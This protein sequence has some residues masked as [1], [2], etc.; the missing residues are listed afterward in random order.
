[1]QAMLYSNIFPFYS[2]TYSFHLSSLHFIC[3][4]LDCFILLSNISSSWGAILP[5]SASWLSLTVDHFLMWSAVFSSEHVFSEVHCSFRCSVCLEFKVPWKS[6]LSL[7]LWWLLGIPTYWGPIFILI[8]GLGILISYGQYKFRSYDVAWGFN[9][10]LCPGHKLPLG[11]GCGTSNVLFHGGAA[12]PG[13]CSEAE[14]L[15]PAPS[16]VCVLSHS[17]SL[18]WKPNASPWPLGPVCGYRSLGLLWCHL[19]HMLL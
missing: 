19:I 4:S 8:S 15:V 11:H 3:L 16:L 13:L 18:A 12:L 2:T 9:Y 17:L 5:F 1:M 7:L 10:V 6:D 14:V